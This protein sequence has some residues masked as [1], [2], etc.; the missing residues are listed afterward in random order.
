MV[1]LRVQSFDPVAVRGSIQHER[2]AWAFDLVVSPRFL[3][4]ILD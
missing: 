3:L 4:P 2:I 1:V